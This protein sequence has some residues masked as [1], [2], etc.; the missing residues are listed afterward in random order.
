MD[1]LVSGQQLLDFE[2]RG[3]GRRT[4]EPRRMAEP[5][6]DVDHLVE[7]A[8]R[9]GDGEVVEAVAGAATTRSGTPSP[10]K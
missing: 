5:R 9:G 1:D 4:R 10:S 6:A 2:G 7:L 3:E 8:D